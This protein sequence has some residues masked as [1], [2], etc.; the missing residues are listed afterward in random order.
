MSF[1]SNTPDESRHTEPKV[2]IIG[3]GPAG[4]TAAYELV[5]KGVSSI[6]LEA[7]SVV[8]GISR[9]VEY[10]SYRFDIGGHRFFTKISIVNRIWHEV[11]GD[12]F[13]TQDRISHIYYRRK[14]Y[15]YPLQPLNVFRNFGP[16]ESALCFASYLK[17]V[18]TPK[19]PEEDFETYI[20][21]RFGRRLYEAFF[22]TYTEKVWGISCK[23]LRADW[24]AQRI[25]GLSIKQLARSIL[26][27]RR[28][29]GEADIIKTLVRRFEYPRHGPGMMWSRMKELAEA[30]GVRVK[31]GARVSR[32]IWEPGRVIAVE[33]GGRCLEAE[34]VI[35][36]MPIRDLIDCLDPPPPPSVIAAGTALAYRDFLTVAL[37]VRGR[38]GRD[39]NW[40]YVHDPDVKVGRIQIFN[41]WSPE[42][43]PDPETTCY[44]LEYFCFEGDEL[45]SMEDGNL[46]ELAKREIERL[47]LFD[48]KLAL[49]GT[50]VR[51][52]KA[53]PVY[54]ENYKNCLLAV[55]EFLGTVPNL[56]LVGRNGMHK[57]N[58][59]DHSMLTAIM[60]ARNIL[61]A[62]YD[63]WA[64]NSDSEYHEEGAEISESDLRLLEETQP[65]VPVSTVNDS[66]E[67]VGR[68]NWQDRS[69]ASSRNSISCSGSDAKHLTTD[70][71]SIRDHP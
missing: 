44:G 66:N 59:Q 27:L 57:Y 49:D 9:T 46:I 3:A 17:A 54:D 37:I 35:S 30:K 33:V 1:D 21:N 39:D 20:R 61:G 69:S 11:L 65:L 12:D 53:Y 23:C 13:I 16:V 41:N 43:V 50:V 63:L 32:I 18:I 71:L 67:Y 45:W 31:L 52:P 64:I 19:L 2:V 38:P 28:D 24:A 58:N 68:R 56:Q 36:S 22:K 8:G 51:M 7:D 60:A 47:G 5:N 34:H 14:F 25:R 62:R 4:L 15:N 10:K 70:N 55:H 6:V 48:S 40:I 26:G 29:R 42:M